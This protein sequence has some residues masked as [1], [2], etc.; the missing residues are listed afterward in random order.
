MKSTYTE[1]HLI[2]RWQTPDPDNGYKATI[3]ITFT[4]DYVLH[5]V[6][7]NQYSKSEIQ[8]TW[9]YSRN[10]LTEYSEY[11]TWQGA[12]QWLTDDYFVLTIIENG[13]PTY[14]GRKR[15]YERLPEPKK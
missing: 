9:A 14:K 1:A 3:T 7:E 15:Y 11:G 13:E 2:G 8:N 4:P 10:I 6:F 12:I 5:Y